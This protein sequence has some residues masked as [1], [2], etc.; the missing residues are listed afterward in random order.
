LVVA[1]HEVIVRDALCALAQLVLGDT[2]VGG[3]ATEIESRA[4]TKTV[5]FGASKE[6][7]QRDLL[8]VSFDIVHG[9]SP[10]IERERRRP[11]LGDAAL[12]MIRL[13]P[14]AR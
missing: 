4:T 2:E 3:F 11:E 10:S 6:V 7:Q 9:L 13:R 12:L 1:G 8:N 14:A 5:D